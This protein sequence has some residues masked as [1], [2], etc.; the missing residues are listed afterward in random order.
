MNEIT[1]FSNP[2]D[3]TIVQPCFNGQAELRGRNSRKSTS[4]E[5]RLTVS[6]TTFLATMNGP[7]FGN[8]GGGGSAGGMDD[9]QTMAAVKNVSLDSQATR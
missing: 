4:T 1:C 5:R 9:P 7:M 8:I 2:R 6:T 3:R